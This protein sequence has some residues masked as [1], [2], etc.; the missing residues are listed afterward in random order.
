VYL[1]MCER[2]D[3]RIAGSARGIFGPPGKHV[4]PHADDR[5]S[6]HI[7]VETIAGASV[8]DRLAAPCAQ[9]SCKSFEDT[10]ADFARFSAGM[11]DDSQQLPLIFGESDQCFGLRLN[12][13]DWLRLFQR[14]GA[15]ARFE[16]AGGLF[17]KLAKK[18]QLVFEVEIERARCESSV[19]GDRVTRDGVWAPFAEKFAS[20][21]EQSQAGR[22]R[23]GR[24]ASLARG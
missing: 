1:K 3:D 7:R 20:G 12:D 22:L 2:P 8:G 4:G 19:S 23:S 14:D 24:T 9:A 5:L 18:R 10:R 13:L 16:F 11:E 17:G 21:V 6:Q 15:K